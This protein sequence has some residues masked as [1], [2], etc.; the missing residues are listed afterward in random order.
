MEH[1]WT[2]AS[3]FQANINF[4]FYEIFRRNRNAKW[5]PNY[6]LM[7]VNI[8]KMS[9]FCIK[10]LPWR[11]RLKKVT[12]IKLIFQYL[13]IF[14]SKILSPIPKKIRF[15]KFFYSSEKIELPLFWFSWCKFC[16]LLFLNISSTMFVFLFIESC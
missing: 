2:I 14:Q 4:P 5:R 10:F 8:R 6:F 1:L 9:D 12:V 13:L 11:N 3:Y 15:P 16:C 7:E